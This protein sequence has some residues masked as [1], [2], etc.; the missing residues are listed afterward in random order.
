MSF[1]LA[2]SF[3]EQADW[4]DQFGSPFTAAL[5]TRAA[6]DIEDGG[7]L[8]SLLAGR[9][10]SAADVPSLRFAGALQNAFMKTAALRALYPGS[11]ARGC[12]GDGWRMD[13]IWPR[14]QALMAARR[15]DFERFLHYAPQTNEARRAIAL[16]P[17]FLAVAAGGGPLHM[18][19]L[20][21][22]AGLNQMWD[23]F[24]YD[25]GSWRWPAARANEAGVTAAADGAPQ[26]DTDWRGPPPAY[27][28]A[29][30]V[31]SRAGCDLNPLRLTRR[32]ERARL[33]AFI[34]PDQPERIDR[35]EAAANLAVR[36][37]V[38][39]ERADAALWLERPLA[40]DLPPRLG[41][42]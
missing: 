7:P 37:G 18:R 10:W 6:R 35:F 13:A 28:G 32:S 40:G 31:A 1:D 29:A 4:C 20:G 16:L 8:A 33:R 14:A 19:E 24:A 27:L 23:S 21:A 30:P 9:A 12:A 36:S 11:G 5:L 38:Q 2:A 3:R 26:I 25:G 41:A 34:W 17:A 39:I 15:G 42:A 22:S